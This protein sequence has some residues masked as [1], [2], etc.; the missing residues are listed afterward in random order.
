MGS[1]A[2][3]GGSIAVDVASVA[4]SGRDD[5]HPDDL[6]RLLVVLNRHL[7]SDSQT[8][9]FSVMLPYNAEDIKI[10]FCITNKLS[11]ILCHIL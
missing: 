9:S 10:L 7:R 8:L 6:V 2:L 5:V 11:T 4:A 3:S 1:L